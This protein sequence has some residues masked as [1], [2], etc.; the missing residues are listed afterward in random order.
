MTE[1]Q[2]HLSAVT[3][4]SSGPIGTATPVDASSATVRAHLHAQLRV[5]RRRAQLHVVNRASGNGGG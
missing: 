5:A 1:S 4:S 2:P 3:G